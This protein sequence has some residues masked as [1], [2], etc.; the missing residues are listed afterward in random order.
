MQARKVLQVSRVLSVPLVRKVSL[1]LT[2]LCR[3]LK[4]R[5]ESLVP[6]VRKARRVMRESLVLQARKVC[7]VTSARKVRKESQVSM[8]LMVP[9][10]Q[11]P[12][13]KVPLVRKVCKA[14][15][16]LLVP[17]VLQVRKVFKA[18]PASVKLMK[19]RSMGRFTDASW[20]RGP[21]SSTRV[22][23]AAASKVQ[24]VPLVLLDLLA[25]L[26]LMA[27]M[28]SMA[29]RVRK[30]HK[31]RKVLQARTASTESMVMTAR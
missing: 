13:R 12:A 9:T 23:A 4:A 27:L 10:R 22:K 29:H 2:R 21:K 1:A 16:V 15:L 25:R 20:R 24:S 7:R 30:D 6:L 17:L 8:A 28:V 19:L 26:V 18:S 3:D 31:A 11:C 5:K 14:S